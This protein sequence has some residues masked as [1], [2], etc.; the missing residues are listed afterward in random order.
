[1]GLT[2]ADMKTRWIVRASQVAWILVVRSPRE[3]QIHSWCNYFFCE[4]TVLSNWHFKDLL[5]DATLINACDECESRESCQSVWADRAR[6][7]IP[8]NGRPLPRQRSDYPWQ[9]SRWFPPCR[10]QLS[11][12]LP[13][14]ITESVAFS[15]HETYLQLVKEKMVFPQRGT[16]CL[17]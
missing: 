11:N 10:E 1:M 7:C 4:S 14:I 2:S 9:S 13:L 17:K 8:N 3:K 15:G 6:E 16:M 12:A 5:P